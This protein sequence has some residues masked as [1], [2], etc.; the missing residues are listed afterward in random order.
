MQPEI[1]LYGNTPLTS[2]YVMSVFVALEEKKLP[3]RL[4][5]LDLAR[6]D[7]HAADFVAHSVT[8]RVPAMLVKEPGGDVWLS[9]SVAILE[10]LEERFAPPEHP[11]IYPRGLVQR[12]RARLVQGL[13]RSDFMPIREERSTETLFAGQAATP[14]SERAEAARVRLVRIAAA[15][16][17]EGQRFITG[18][19]SIADVDLSTLLQ[20]LIH[21]GDPLPAHLAQY[22][23]GVW[24]RPSIEKWL[25]LTQYRR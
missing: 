17:A 22:A 11:A 8:N 3:F 5:L 20:R 6:G 21:N 13:I 4:E 25:G 18:E 10:Y 9:E 24:Q 12:A 7:Q 14:L 16:V 19:F 2:P 15:L 23:Q 1:V